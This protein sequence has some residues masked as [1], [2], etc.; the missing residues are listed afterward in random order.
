MLTKLKT[1]VNNILKLIIDCWT[2]LY[3]IGDTVHI[4][5]YKHSYFYINYIKITQL[6]TYIFDV[7]PNILSFFRTKNFL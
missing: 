2:I 4:L 6:F 3:E 1:I 5:C 7:F